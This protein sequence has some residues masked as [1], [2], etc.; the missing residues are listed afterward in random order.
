MLK[1]GT[2]LPSNLCA[3]IRTSG[4]MENQERICIII[5]LQFRLS[6]YLNSYHE[7][8]HVLC[9]SSHTELVLLLL[10]NGIYSLWRPLC[11]AE[12]CLRWWYNA[13]LRIVTQHSSER[14]EMFSVAYSCVQGIFALG[15]ST[16]CMLT[17]ITA[18]DRA[19]RGQSRIRTIDSVEMSRLSQTLEERTSMTIPKREWL[20]EKDRRRF[21]RRL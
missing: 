11:L 15:S 17:Y 8:I 20:C 10:L 21:R 14:W 7:M 1:R 6:K 2:L 5:L 4:V 3:E 16:F 13:S 12:S 18:F 19:I 9:R